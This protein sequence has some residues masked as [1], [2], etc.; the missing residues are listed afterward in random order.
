M[1]TGVANV[2]VGTRQVANL[3]SRQLDD[4]EEEED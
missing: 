3:P 1:P 2:S 4:E